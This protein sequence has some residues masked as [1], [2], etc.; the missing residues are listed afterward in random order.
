MSEALNTTAE[1]TL[2]LG[3]GLTGQSIARWLQR[4][5]RSAVFADTRE[6]ADAAAIQRELPDA[7]VVAAADRSVLEGKTEV[8]TS[9]GVAEHDPIIRASRELGIPVYSDI[10]IFAREAIAPVVAVTGTNGKSTVVS[11]LAHMCQQAGMS[12]SVGGNLGTPALDLVE[13]GPDGVYLLELSS[14]Q[15]A[16]TPNLALQSGCLLNVEP[17]HIDWHGSFESYRAAKMKILD[18]CAY[19]ILPTDMTQSDVVIDSGAVR[20]RFGVQPPASVRD[21]GV[22]DFEGRR[23]WASGD[24]R[25]LAIDEAA[26][27]GEHNVLN[28]AAALAIGTS[29]DLPLSAMCAAIRSFPGL[30]HRHQLVTVRDDVRF[31]DDS[32]ATNCAAS[33][34][35]AR[36]VNGP[37][38]LLVG[39]LGKG[40]DYLEFAQSLPAQVHHVI[41]Y[42]ALA[43]TLSA[44]LRQTRITHSEVADLPAAVSKAHELSRAGDT[45]LLAPAAASQDAYVDYK[46]RGQHFRAL[47]TEEGVL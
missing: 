7:T 2:V 9:P 23:Y 13:P 29:I 14:F 28:V 44:A 46:Q 27:I 5:G 37:V 36:A 30:D 42:G 38:I 16:R 11:L 25:L 22:V 8:I 43:P 10:A 31:V 47:V 19:A 20:L 6:R 15:L 4:T 33:L 41:V 18:H 40:E 24:T 34:V 32:K 45:V 17:D 39:G 1:Q 26:L 3:T 21:V 12:F 35:S